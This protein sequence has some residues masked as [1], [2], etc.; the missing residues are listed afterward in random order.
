MAEN[1]IDVAILMGSDSDLP[2]VSEV[3][4]IFDEFGVKYTKSV[5]SAHRSPHQ[6]IELIKTSESNGC[7]LFIAAAGMAAHFAGAVAAHSFKPVIGIPIESGGLGGLD[8]LLSTA[9]MPPGIPVATVAIG[10][11][12]AKNSAIL[13]I[14]MLSI[15]DENMADKFSKY[16]A[17]LTNE[18][19]E[20]NKNLN[21]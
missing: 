12:G 21:A 16:R 4:K 5:L 1:S 14:Q 17:N 6:V 15:S 13:A 9:Q 8:A 18:V 19:L 11:A 7:K 20:K 2:V 10:K 3:F